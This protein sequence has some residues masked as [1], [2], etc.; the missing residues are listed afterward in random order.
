MFHV[1][2]VCS[3]YAAVNAVWLAKTCA[4]LVSKHLDVFARMRQKGPRKR[5]TLG[6]L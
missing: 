1:M 5:R 2:L 3:P 4:V 6:T